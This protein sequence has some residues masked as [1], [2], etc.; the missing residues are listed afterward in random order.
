MSAVDNFCKPDIFFGT[1]WAT[2]E[3][4]QCVSNHVFFAFD[5]DLSNSS[6]PN[7][8]FLLILC[9]NLYMYMMNLGACKAWREAKKDICF[10]LF[11]YFLKRTSYVAHYC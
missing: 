10:G 8:S 2:A 3:E 5:F 9:T 11:G 4:E 7:D 6:I 1:S